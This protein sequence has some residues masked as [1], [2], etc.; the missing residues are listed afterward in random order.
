[1]LHKDLPLNET[2]EFTGTWWIPDQP[3]SKSIGR[4]TLSPTNGILLRIE[5]PDRGVLATYQGC[6]VNRNGTIH[7]VLFNG[8]YEISILDA[9]SSGGSQNRSGMG[10]QNVIGNVCVVGKHISSRSEKFFDSIDLQIGGLTDWLRHNPFDVSFS[11]TD[12]DLYS[13]RCKEIDSVLDFEIEAEQLAFSVF[14]NFS[15]PCSQFGDCEVKYS[16]SLIIQGTETFS[17][18]DA[19]Q[20]TYSLENLFSIMMGMATSVLKLKCF[21]N[22]DESNKHSVYIPLYDRQKLLSDTPHPGDILVPFPDF[23]ESMPSIFENWFKSQETEKASRGLFASSFREKFSYNTPRFLNCVQALEVVAQEHVVA[24]GG[25]E[26]GIVDQATF[27][28][29]KSCFKSLLKKLEID[30][31]A[32]GLLCDKFA[33]INGSPLRSKVDALVKSMPET[34]RNGL[35]LD[36]DYIAKVIR[37]RNFYTHYG[38]KENIFDNDQIPRVIDKLECLLLIVQLRSLSID[39]EYAAKK[40]RSLWRYNHCFA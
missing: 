17:M 16:P 22:G 8:Q 3:D 40:L 33:R 31:S 37:T 6:D 13:L 14:R 19:E 38:K 28:N 12:G 5:S 39:P 1:M 11:D 36:D 18:S 29:L 10:H 25:S 15:F 23:K 7:G 9:F 2:H 30:P 4:L 34:V 27:K 32:I 35:T 21:C 20:L 26:N 24:C